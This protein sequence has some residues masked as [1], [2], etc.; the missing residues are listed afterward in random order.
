[1]SK[2]SLFTIAVLG[3]SA[4][5][6]AATPAL[7]QSTPSP[8]PAPAPAPAPVPTP[9]TAPGQ[10]KE[11]LAEQYARNRSELE[12][13][14][15]MSDTESYAR[16]YELADFVSRCVVDKM[17]ED[18][19]KLVGGAMTDDEE[20][21]ALSKAMARPL[22]TCLRRETT[23]LPMLV[24]NGALAENL[25][26][27]REP[28]LEPRAMSVNQDEADAFTAMAPGVRITFDMIGR[29]AAVYSPGLT[30]EVLKS[31]PGSN[32][33]EEA[34]DAL[35]AATPECGLAESPEG[36]PAT[37]QRSVLASGLFHWLHRG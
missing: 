27:A 4:V 30:Y 37:Y 32:A 3:I 13:R 16:A 7:A 17:G 33:E 34:L 1:M 26:R 5:T 18:A 19:A 29:C 8:S 14:Q 24:V 12:M 23:G 22:R 10:S 11:M 36:A 9:T 2:T 35:Y 25:V 6:V 21:K 20:Y 31:K 15:I 28:Q